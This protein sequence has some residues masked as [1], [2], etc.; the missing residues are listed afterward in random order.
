MLETTKSIQSE[1]LR[2]TTCHFQ[3]TKTRNTTVIQTITSVYDIG[4]VKVKIGPYSIPAVNS[5]PSKS[6]HK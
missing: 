4:N 2:D 6:A 3:S 1:L 5:G